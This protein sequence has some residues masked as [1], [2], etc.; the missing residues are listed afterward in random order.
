M[1]SSSSKLKNVA[2]NLE[3][4]RHE[5]KNALNMLTLAEYQYNGNTDIIKSIAC[6]ID[7]NLT[8]QNLCKKK[9]KKFESEQEGD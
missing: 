4:A 2:A 7:N 8:V 3:D 5:L 9:T 1:A 6:Y